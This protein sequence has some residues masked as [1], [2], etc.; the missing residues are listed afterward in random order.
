VTRVAPVGSC[1]CHF[2]V[3]GKPDVYPVRH[4]TVYE[5]PASGLDEALAMHAR[6]GIDRGI[7]VHP[8]IYGTDNALLLNTLE[9]LP[10]DR[11]R[12]VALVDETTSDAELERLHQ[13]GV[14]GAR[15]HFFPNLGL[16]PDIVAFRRS[17]ERIARF[18]WFAKVFAGGTELVEIET[19]LANA[20]VPIVL[21]HICKIDF[22][23]GLEQPMHRLLLRL[24][25]RE[26]VWMQLSNGDTGK[27]GPFVPPWHEAVPFGRA[28][29]AA[30]PAR[31]VWG[32]DFPH[33]LYSYSGNP[34]KPIP[35]D[36]DLLDLLF[37]YLP[38]IAAREDVLVRNPAQLL[39][40]PVQM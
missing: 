7:V 34:R 36:A 25:E 11:Y 26:H 35:D 2:H 8:T 4:K 6:V 21:D 10:S 12:G 17:L 22:T 13:A 19:E 28:Y 9:R 27:D 38:G 29:Y 40:F 3:F 30:A 31:T 16:V 37:D 15:F 33:V 23:L 14:R 1:D 18:G 20:C 39:G 24:L 5:L 32:S